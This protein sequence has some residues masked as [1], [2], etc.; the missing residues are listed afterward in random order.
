MRLDD[1]EEL[2]GEALLL[3]TGKHELRGAARPVDMSTRPLGLR[4]AL[5]PAPALDRRA[6][7]RDRAPSV[8][9]RL[10]RPAAPGG[11]HGQS[12]P[13]RV[14]RP[15]EVGRRASKPLVARLAGE[16]PAFAERL[17]QGE[18]GAWSAVSGIPYGWRARG[19]VD[20]VYRVGDQAAVIA[21]LAG[22]GIAIAL[23]SGVAAARA[24]AG[25]RSAADYQRDWA[26]RARRPVGIAEALR[27]SAEHTGVAAGDDGVGRLVSR[28]GAAGGAADADRLDPYPP[29]RSMG[30]G[31]TPKGWWRGN[32]RGLGKLPLHQLRTVPLPIASRWGGSSSILLPVAHVDV[33]AAARGSDLGEHAQRLGQSDLDLG[34]G[35]AAGV[36]DDLEIDVV[37]DVEAGGDGGAA[38]GRVVG[39]EDSKPVEAGRRSAACRAG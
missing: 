37:A 33:V 22:D 2:A 12:L 4:S 11:R 30:R 26:K 24:I 9:R 39:A 21:S 1:D 15:A 29:R 20:G 6:G 23:E 25:G 17:G 13:L 38:A 31:T 5:V 10:C 35:E 3:A 28:A 14:A 18:P 7:G 27:R 36:G 8:R 32:R 19:T 34:G 16:L